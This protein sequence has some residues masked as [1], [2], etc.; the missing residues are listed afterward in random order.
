MKEVVRRLVREARQSETIDIIEV[1][2]LAGAL[3]GGDRRRGCLPALVPG[4][5]RGSARCAARAPGHLLPGSGARL[6][7]APRI[8]QQLRSPHPATPSRRGSTSG[9][10][11]SRSSG[12]RA[13]PTT[14]TASSTPISCSS[15][16]RRWARP[17]TRS[18]FLPTAGDTVFVNMYL[19]YE[20]LSEGL[21]KALGGLQGINESG[22]PANYSTPGAM[23]GK[24]GEP[25]AASHPVVRTH[26]VTG[27]KSLFVSPGFTRRFE[28]MTAEESRPAHRLPVRACSAA[29]V[30]VPLP[31]VSESDRRS[32][33]TGSVCTARCRTS[34][35]RST[36]IAG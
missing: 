2:P 27:R 21:K 6:R 22:A 24:N 15:R 9:R 34:L 4:S 17:S 31:L 10:K 35:E 20:T 23:A 7:A 14:G 8:R 13:S 26:P 36:S 12:P 11:P 19:A 18:K 3:E 16:S 25:M 28:D 5:P 1:S 33:T 32:G 30:H 29:R